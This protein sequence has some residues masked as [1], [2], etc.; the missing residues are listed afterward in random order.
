MFGISMRVN[1]PANIGNT[2]QSEG[3][4]LA[5]MCTDDGGLLQYGLAMSLLEILFLGPIAWYHVGSDGNFIPLPFVEFGVNC[6]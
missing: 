5:G 6:P 2:P 3:K 1:I 4:K